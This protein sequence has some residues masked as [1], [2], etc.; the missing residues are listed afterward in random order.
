MVRDR[1]DRDSPPEVRPLRL[2]VAVDVPQ[3]VMDQLSVVVAPYRNRIP[4]ARWTRGEGWHVTLKFLGATWPRLM[5]NVRGAVTQAASETA[6]FESALTVV[7]AFP[8]AARARVLWAGMSDPEG[9]FPALAKLL[10]ELLAEHF[11][12]EERPFSPHLTLARLVPPRN[13]AEFVPGL[14]GSSV[15]SAPFPVERLVLYRSLLSPGGARYEPML[16]VP[17]TG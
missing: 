1:T 6:P 11:E 4:G 3:A 7:G 16:T 15:G 8:S 13:L 17:F 12:P 14:H 10:N 2:F 5:E 9:R